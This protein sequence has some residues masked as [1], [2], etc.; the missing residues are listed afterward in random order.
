MLPPPHSLHTE[1]YL[2]CLHLRDGGVRAGGALAVIRRER[3]AVTTTAADSAPGRSR[4]S[5]RA[6]SQSAAARAPWP[7]P[8]PAIRAACSC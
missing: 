6:R 8:A 4:R 1:W 5:R 3:D 2:P 7:A